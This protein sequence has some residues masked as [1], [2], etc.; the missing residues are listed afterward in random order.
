MCPKSSSSDERGFTLIEATISL[1]LLLVVL[2]LSMGFLISM[3]T[4]SQRQEMFTEPRQTARRAIDYMSYYIRGAGDMNFRANA[5]DALVSHYRLGGADQQACYN[6]VS[7]AAIADLDTDL[8]SIATLT[9]SGTAPFNY[10]SGVTSSSPSV[11]GFQQGCGTTTNDTENLRLFKSLTGAHMEGGQ[12]VSNLMLMSDS[13]GAWAY[14]KITAYGASQCGGSATLPCSSGTVSSCPGIQVTCN[15]A[16]PMDPPGG[17][18]SIGSPSLNF[19]QL[20]CFRV[21]GGQL[22]QK[23]APFN[24]AN[25]TAT[26]DALFSPLLD[27]IE[28]LQVAYIYN[29]GNIYNQ[30]VAGRL[31]SPGVPPQAGPTVTTPGATDATNVIGMRVSV[32]GRSS[33]IGAYQQVTKNRYFR[34]AS[35]DRAAGAP[36]R[37]YHYRLT[38]TI[39]LRNRAL[40]Y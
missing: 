35:E 13:S 34:P 10:L 18:V 14:Y 39:L 4:F 12:T 28:D 29:D 20:S 30:S 24:P 1:T 21:K 22:Q 3:R 17:A 8:F 23:S 27:N 5:P 11:V 32:V 33:A 26:E 38:S 40:G 36:D 19:V 15:P 37:S 7:S 25:A 31:P 16:A 9:Y 2:I 6:N